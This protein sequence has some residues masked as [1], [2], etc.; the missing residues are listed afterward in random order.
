MSKFFDEFLGATRNID[1]LQYASYAQMPELPASVL[2]FVYF[3]ALL[4]L[5]SVKICTINVFCNFFSH[6]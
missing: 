6:I 5:G 3:C 2:E 1:A 4:N